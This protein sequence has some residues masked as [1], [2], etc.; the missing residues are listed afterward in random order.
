[1]AHVITDYNVQSNAFFMNIR[2]YKSGGF[3][4]M[5]GGGLIMWYI[6]IIKDFKIISKYQ[7]IYIYIYEKLLVLNRLET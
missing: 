6:K 4:N 7:N 2:H 3:K 5:K 1:M